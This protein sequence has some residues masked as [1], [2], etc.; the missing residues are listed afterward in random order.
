MKDDDSIVL[1][2]AFWAILG[3]IILL[4]LTIVE[5]WGNTQCSGF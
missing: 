1:A 2:L 5:L 3:C 4:L